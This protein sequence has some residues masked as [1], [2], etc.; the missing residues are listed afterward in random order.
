MENG[1]NDLN[2]INGKESSSSDSEKNKQNGNED[3]DKKENEKDQGKKKRSRAKKD[4]YTERPFKCHICEKTFLSKPALNT[5]H[6]KKHNVDN[7]NKRGRPE[8]KIEIENNTTIARKKYNSFFD[9]PKRKPTPSTQTDNTINTITLAEAK[10]FI[11]EAF[12]LYKTYLYTHLEK[13]E[14]YP[15]YKLVLDNWDKAQPQIEEESLLDNNKT[16][17]IKE[18]IKKHTP[19]ID[20][21]FYL[22]LKESSK[23]TNVNYF[24]NM[25]K[26]IVLFREKI[27]EMKKNV[28]TEDVIEENKKEYTQIF[29]GGEISELCNDFIMTFMEPNKYFDFVEEDVVELLQHLCFWLYENQYSSSHL[30]LI[31]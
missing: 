4:D 13:V 1:Q 14:D 8:K 27:N 31:S 17:N 19:C 26:F 3:K 9:N 30:T 15:L 12:D 20:G 29:N 11:S 5:H 18:K 6:K 21:L 22:Y 25:V 16:R 23:K 24:F 28:V 7:P 10:S 2:K